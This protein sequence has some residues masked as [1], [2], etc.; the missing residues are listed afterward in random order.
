MF[1]LIGYGQ[2]NFFMTHT[3]GS[4]ATKPTVITSG[5]TA[6]TSTTATGGGNVLLDGGATVTARGICWSVGVP[7]V[8]SDHTTDGSG[9]GAFT[10]SIAAGISG[11]NTYLVRAYATNSVGTEYGNIVTFLT[12]VSGTLPSVTTSESVTTEATG[13]YGGG[14]VTSDGGNTV[15]G[16][17]ICYSTSEN[18]TIA[19]SKVTTTGT[20]GAFTGLHMTSLT[21]CTSYWI[22]AYATNAYGT[23][24]GANVNFKTLSPDRN[25][26]YSFIYVATPNGGT[27]V[28]VTSI[29]TGQDVCDMFYTY[30]G[31]G[32][33]WTSRTYGSAAPV[34]AG[35]SMWEIGRCLLTQTGYFVLIL[36]AVNYDNF[37]IIYLVNGVVSSVTDYNI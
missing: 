9:T 15:T 36:D 21:S 10:S 12:P 8:S 35:V 1:T 24:Y 7:T 16:R 14:N 30:H 18:P 26:T 19:G 4:A 22:R 32:M 34:E 23:A 2:G 6:I 37:Q 28:F 17:G 25:H 29:A 27:S 13:A 3:Y 33:S 31:T 20:T 5:I 11:G